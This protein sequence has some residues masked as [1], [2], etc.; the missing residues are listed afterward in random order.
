MT[1]T[2]QDRKKGNIVECNCTYSL[3]GV[4]YILKNKCF[5]CV[6]F[7]FIKNNSIAFQIS[8]HPTVLT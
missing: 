5:L 4:Y 1:V 8:E 6:F 7:Y 3:V 2:A